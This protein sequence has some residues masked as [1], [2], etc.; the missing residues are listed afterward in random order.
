MSLDAMQHAALAD[1]A[2]DR[3]RR[4]AGLAASGEQVRVGNATYTVLDHLDHRSSGYQGTVYRN[5][6][7]GD[8]VV[9]HRG[10][11]PGRELIPDGLTDVRMVMQRCN[12]QA[13]HAIELTRRALAWANDPDA[14][15][16]AGRT[17]EV[18]VTGH[19]LGGTLAQISAHHFGLRG[20]TFNAYGAASLD[21]RIPRG[22]GRVDNH[23]MATDPVSA[24]SQHYGP[25][26]IHAQP[27]EIARLRSS[28]YHDNPLLDAL[29]RDQPILAAGRSLGAHGMHN[30]LDVDA[31]GRPDVSVLR[32]PATQRL[33]EKHQRMI[34]DYRGDVEELRRGITAGSRGPG[35]LLGDGIDWLRR[36]G[37]SG[38]PP[39]REEE[40][41]D[42]AGGC[43]RLDQ[44]LGGVVDPAVREAWSRDVAVQRER[45]RPGQEHEA[46][47]LAQPS[48]PPPLPGMEH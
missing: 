41:A 20:V 23:V 25:V 35:G 26:T 4:M 17:P 44:L 13:G 22:E 6:D 37:R 36:V 40:P 48:R 47:A 12:A 32:D 3:D 27:Q 33:A 18:S 2:Y 38:W 42:V 34:A 45:V 39:G 1:H 28:G 15:A 8:I 14:R 21:P 5:R 10:S 7:S 16:E 9:A 46:P 29:F 31:A 30:F 11:E 24:A 43:S 19:S